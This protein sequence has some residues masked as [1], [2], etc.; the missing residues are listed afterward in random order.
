MDPLSELLGQSPGM[1]TV[2]EEL[3]RLLTLR[4]ESRRPP[5]ILIQ[6]ETGTGKGLLARALHRGGPRAD[7]PFVDINCA[8]IPETLIEAELFGFERGAFTDARQAKPGLFQI[9]HGGMIFLDEVGL[10][11]EGLQA[12]LLK[13][14]EDQTV[15]R[16]GGTRAE[17]VDVW[18]VAATSVDLLQAIQEGRFRQDLFHRL[19]VVKVTLPPLRTR[20]HDIVRLAEHF[21]NRACADYGLPRRTLVPEARAAL[22]KHA[23]PGNV[24]E[25]ANLM[26]RVALLSET[27]DVRA[28]ML[29]L[30]VTPVRSTA[31]T[32]DRQGRPT[33]PRSPS[34][35]EELLE[36]LRQT[37]WNVTAAAARLGLT[38]NTIR[39]R[40]ESLGLE[41][42]R[43]GPGTRR[44]EPP[45][46]APRGEPPDA[47]VGEPTDAGRR[48]LSFLGVNVIMP[49]D[50]SP[51]ETSGA[52]ETVIDKIRSF[53]GRE[54]ERGVTTIGAVFGLEPLDDPPLR[55]AHAALAVQKATERAR[56]E[57]FRPYAVRVGIHTAALPVTGDGD[58]AEIEPGG[59]RE[60]QTLMATLLAQAE[61]GRVLLTAGI[62]PFLERRLDLVP[63][64]AVDG[65]PG[66]V[67]RLVG[68]ER[69]E[70]GPTRRLTTF[71]GRRHDLEL[72]QGRLNSAVGGRGQVVGIVG[73]AGLGKSRLLHEFRQGLGEDVRYVE[74]RCLPYGSAIPYL[75]L[76]DI[77]RGHCGIVDTDS[78]KLIVEKV[79]RGLEEV[80]MDPA[81]GAPYLLQLLGIR[82]G[83][84]RLAV[85]SPEAIKA[86]TFETQRQLGLKGSR[87]RPLVLA[88]ENVHWIDK[89]SDEYLGALVESLGGAPILLILTYRPGYR[90]AWIERSYATQ[91]ALQPLT[92]DDGASIVRSMLETSEPLAAITPVIVAKAEGNPL[93]L[94]E[95]ALAVVEQDGGSGALRIPDTLQEV[96]LSRMQRLSDDCRRVLQAAAVIGR[97]FSLRLLAEL[98]QEP[99]GLE[100]HLV[101]LRRLEFVYEKSGAEEPAYVFRHALTQE[102]AYE[103]LP[104]TRRRGLHATAARAL[105]A[106]YADR[107]EA[108]YDRVA[109]HYARAEDAHRAIYYLTRAAEKAARSYAHTEAAAA[110]REALAFVERMAPGERDR[111]QVDLALRQAHSLYFLGRFPDTLALLGDQHDAVERLRDPALAGAYHFWLAHTESHLGRHQAAVAAA[112]RSIGEARQAGDEPTLGKAHY[113]LARSGFWSG[114][115]HQSVAEGRQAVAILERT[116]ERWWL[117]LAYWGVAFGLGFLG[118]FRAALEATARADALGNAIGDPRLQTY[119]AWTTGWLQAAQGDLDAALAACR[120]S[121]ERS[122]DPVNTADAL[123]FL[124]YVLVE[125]GAVRDAIPLLEQSIKQWTEFQH[126]LML[127]WFT[128]VL[129]DAYLAAG[130]PERAHQAASRGLALA[131]EA[132]FPY[133]AALA[134]RTLARIARSRGRL[135]EAAR[136][137]AEALDTFQVIEAR[138]ESA[139]TGLELAA[140]AAARGD[141]AAAQTYLAEAR[142]LF[143]ATEVRDP[144]LLI[145]DVAVKLGV[146]LGSEADVD[147]HRAAGPRGR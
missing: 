67:F 144:E 7:G 131:R 95:L 77:L 78:P 113:V 104:A 38:R 124:G 53:G 72:L 24:R 40:M 5:P 93:F 28:E 13:V 103:S 4:T 1:V 89:T 11:P 18:V 120:K 141:P 42:D 46:V 52:L 20:G 26:E 123:S 43:P 69:A 48:H 50:T 129:A 108:V 106:Q 54:I 32:P 132:A 138:Y 3:G 83:T 19:A 15:R 70:P 39:Y 136:L 139:R 116:S 90:P 30:S 126:T 74:G 99:G 115:F 88:I 86:R 80:G 111:V 65:V 6:G 97:E 71:V 140:I 35:R 68:R 12:K 135:D 41:A 105:E 55:A 59:K 112:E 36:A 121:L 34:E 137:A 143:Q 58:A 91:I 102:V 142:R 2:R 128:T 101:D 107:L 110:L 17:V 21:L 98:W 29:G 64:G 118:E 85:L 10:L 92:G 125:Q 84:E 145:Q 63:V 9:A 47:R 117:G 62:A 23:W 27:Q 31:R 119:A 75:P 49:P 44:P 81:E 45:V 25:L 37:N 82:D 133:G 127:A 51:A 114:R 76:L 134:T 87:R 147:P 61:P 56:R 94:E 79:R 96:L 109:H 146:P 14:I 8:A 130:E 73:E 16:L 60:I 66:P 100:P 22:L 33:A 57:E 122:P